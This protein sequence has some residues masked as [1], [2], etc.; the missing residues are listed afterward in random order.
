MQYILVICLGSFLG[1]CGSIDKRTM[2]SYDT[3]AKEREAVVRNDKDG[4]IKF[5]ICEV[6]E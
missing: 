3:C 6:K 1:V 5:A 2:P 4:N